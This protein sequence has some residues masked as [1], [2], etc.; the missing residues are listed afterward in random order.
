VVAPVG[1]V[2][3]GG[4]N[5]FFERAK[6]VG[7]EVFCASYQDVKSD[8]EKEIRSFGLIVGAEL[9]EDFER[10][11]ASAVPDRLVH[12]ESASLEDLAKADACVTATSELVSLSGSVVLVSHNVNHRRATSLAPNLF[13]LCHHPVVYLSVSDYLEHA[14]LEP[15]STLTF[16]SGPSSTGD[17]EQILIRGVHGPKRVKVYIYE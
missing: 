12:Y 14:R 3:P 1:D 6:D 9:E 16:V 11:L 2:K 5:T 10:F 8:L 4:L 13:I 15:N 17:I 7:T